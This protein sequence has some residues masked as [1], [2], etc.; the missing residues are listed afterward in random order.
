LVV[1]SIAK[2]E[3]NR[4]VEERTL[5]SAILKKEKEKLATQIKNEVCNREE[6][7]SNS[8]AG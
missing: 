6:D 1:S 8:I 7:L 3:K 4:V 2:L 5:A